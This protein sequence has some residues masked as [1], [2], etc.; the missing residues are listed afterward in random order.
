MNRVALTLA[1]VVAIV[2]QALPAAALVCVQPTSPGVFPPGCL[3]W[4]PSP[5]V[6]WVNTNGVNTIAAGQVI[7]CT[8]LLGTSNP[9]TCVKRTFI[10]GGVTTWI[11]V[12]GDYDLPPPPNWPTFKVR[13][14]KS[15]VAGTVVWYNETSWS[16]SSFTMYPGFTYTTEFN[17]WQ[18]SSVKVTN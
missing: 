9:G 18:A 14:A 5:P 16:G 7:M 8:G 4:A 13:S 17:A 10:N 12:L 15:G 11:P 2:S 1:F 6:D 3:T